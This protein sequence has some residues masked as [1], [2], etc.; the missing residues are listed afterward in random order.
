MKF[1]EAKFIIFFSAYLLFLYCS[2]DK[3]TAIDGTVIARFIVIDTSGTVTDR[4]LSDLAGVPGARVRVNCVE[5]YDPMDL[6]T[7]ENGFF[8]LDN[9]RA[10]RYRISADKFIPRATN[11]ELNQRAIA[12]QLTGSIELDLSRTPDPDSRY[13][14][15][16]GATN[17]SSIVM[18]EIYY[19]GPPNSGIYYSDQFIELYN[20]SDSIQYLDQLLICRMYSEAVFAN[21]HAAYCYYQF[22]GSGTDYPIEPGQLVV[23][24][25]D[26]IDH[27]NAGGAIG[28]IDL[29]HA[30]WEFYNQLSSDL[31]NPNVPNVLNAE[32]I[33]DYLDFFM[34]LFYDKVCLIQ[35]DDL[36]AVPFYDESNKLFNIQDIVDGV[37]YAPE[38]DHVKVLD[39]RIDA[40]L[41]G[42]TISA[43]SGK[44]IERHHPETGGPGYDSNNSTFDFVRLYHPTPGWQHSEQ[45]IIPRK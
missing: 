15:Y 1:R 18:N 31:D 28:S 38:A 35:V 26:A 36:D 40:G 2:A 11:L 4:S 12:V 23:V 25:Q 3:P 39:S 24:A 6:K 45:D 32:P 30:D 19:S 20:A 37:E 41:A 7:D 16:M 27:V 9:V 33:P 44:S 8:E 21:Q 13:V 17:L 43:Y 42:Y 10:A 5:Y 29:S 22:P 34:N 14:I